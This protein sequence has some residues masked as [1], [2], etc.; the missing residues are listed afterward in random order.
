MTRRAT[1]ET[2]VETPGIIAAALK[3][4]NTTE[5]TTQV[6]DGTVVTSIERETTSGLRSTVDDYVVN[7]EVALDVVQ[8]ANQPTQP[9]T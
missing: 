4:D 8:Y 6:V 5:M 2:T 7:L 1:I 9:D 3:P